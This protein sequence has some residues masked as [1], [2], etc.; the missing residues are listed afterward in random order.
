MKRR[1]H[2]IYRRLHLRWLKLRYRL[3]VIQLAWQLKFMFWLFHATQKLNRW[4]FLWL[5]RH[6]VIPMQRTSEDRYQPPLQQRY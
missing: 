3:Y 5:V 2:L 6:D 4:A 1:L